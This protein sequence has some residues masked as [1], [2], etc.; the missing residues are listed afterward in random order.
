MFVRHCIVY[1]PETFSIQN[2]LCRRAEIQSHASRPKNAIDSGWRSLNAVP[3]FPEHEAATPL[4]HT[5]FNTWERTYRVVQK[6]VFWKEYYDTSIGI[7]RMSLSYRV[8][9]L[10]M[11]ILG[12]R[13][14]DEEMDLEAKDSRIERFS[15]WVECVE[16]YCH[17]LIENQRLDLPSLQIMCLF[18]LYKATTSDRNEARRWLQKLV[19][20]ALQ[21]NLHIDPSKLDAMTEIEM[22]LRRQLWATIAEIDIQ[23]ALE[24]GNVL[25]WTA[26][27]VY[28]CGL[29]GSFGLNNLNDQVHLESK[30]VLLPP[31]LQ[32][33]LYQSVAPRIALLRNSFA[34]KGHAKSEKELTKGIT[35]HIATLDGICA[36]FNMSNSDSESRILLRLHILRPIIKALQSLIYRLKDCDRLHETMNLYHKHAMEFLRVYLKLSTGSRNGSL[37]SCTLFEILSPIIHLYVDGSRIACEYLISKFLIFYAWS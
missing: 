7:R 29:P 31:H 22:K 28:H 3:I 23:V 32:I 15:T 10:A 26:S 9:A 16:H 35:I 24:H 11:L 5:Y 1:T 13:A 2:E 34:N 30:H 17:L 12:Q 21:A 18:S 27:C 36:A 33:A 14:T 4:L 25:P 37:V 8:L 19:K 20:F 6:D